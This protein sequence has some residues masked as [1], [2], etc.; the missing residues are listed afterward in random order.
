MVRAIL[1]GAYGVVLVRTAW[2]SDDAFITLRTVDNLVHGHGLRWNVAERVQSFTHPLW[3]ALVAAAYAVTRE[4]YYTVLALSLA[5]SLAAAWIVSFRLAAT[6]ASGALALATLLLSHAYVDYSTSGLENPLSH[7]L[8]ATF[9][10]RF[11]GAGTGPRHLVVL[12]GLAGLATLNRPD[13][14][15]LFIPALAVAVLRSGRVMGLAHVAAGF[16]PLLAWELFATWYYGIPYPN[17][18][19][20]KLNTGIPAGELAV[21]GLRYLENSLR[22]DPLTLAFIAGALALAAARRRL[23]PVAL[24]AGA[25]VYLGYLVRIGGDF[26]SGRFLTAPLLVSAVAVAHLGV[27]GS[28]AVRWIPAALVLALG[29]GAPNPTVLSGPRCDLD[30]S[31]Y[32]DGHGV[33]D[34]R[35]FHF[36]SLGLLSGQPGWSRPT[37]PARL[38]GLELR[39]QGAPVAVEGGVGL[40]GFYAGPGVHVLDSLALGDPLLSRLPMVA[41]DPVAR[42]SFRIGHFTRT[43]PEGYLA[44]LLTGENRIRD[45][46]T[47]ALWDRLALVTRGPLLGAGR[48]AEIA[49][50][51]LGGWS[52]LVERARP[53]YRPVIWDEYVAARPDA[54]EGYYR[55]AVAA[56]GR[57]DAA[58][59]RQDLERA[60]ERDPRHYLALLRLAELELQSGRNTAAA[61]A[62]ARALALRPELAGAHD[63]LAR[64]M[65]AL[66]RLPEAEAL[67]LQAAALDRSFATDAYARVGLVRIAARD[68]AG[69]LAWIERA[70]ALEPRS[71][72]LHLARGQALLGAGRAD[73]G[74]AALERAVELAGEDPEPVLALAEAW[75]ASRRAD[76]AI[77]ALA[78]WAAAHAADARVLFQ[79]GTLYAAGG[80]RDLA[81]RSFA[82]AARLGFA[83]AARALEALQPR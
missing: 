1:L 62:A 18:A 33:S 70:I 28:R 34:E 55:R 66:G 36:P 12:G 82:G 23:G 3:M 79:L 65:W 49:R 83:P 67:F 43:V 6:P 44:T 68:L 48:L 40:V 60:L 72:R 29:L 75:V 47:A 8:V 39:R 76:R 5:S 21:Q 81:I 7:L 10:L 26:M 17:T 13:A 15:L 11:F 77:S 27:P 71:P 2:V 35:R 16:T 38:R 20:A 53:P 22:W 52:P 80:E 30:V 9:A 63:M 4:P 46:R 64:S 56:L 37:P 78:R 42:G 59:A 19:L 32:I 45:A 73:E 31:E 58:P 24:L 54:A 57:D 41:R 74:V 50:A 61:D 14:L 25:L 69:G 51:N